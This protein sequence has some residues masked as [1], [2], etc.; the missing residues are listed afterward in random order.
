[1]GSCL[2]AA[3]APTTAGWPASVSI[4]MA[5]ARHPAAVSSFFFRKTTLIAL[6]LF[7]S[8]PSDSRFRMIDFMRRGRLRCS[9]VKT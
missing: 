7:I 6:I 1:M 8:N 5:A 3:A 2:V 4:T 9:S